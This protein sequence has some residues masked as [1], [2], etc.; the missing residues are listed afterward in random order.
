MFTV[1]YG[2]VYYH[3]WHY[4]SDSFT[5]R[6]NSIPLQYVY[7]DSVFPAFHQQNIYCF[8]SQQI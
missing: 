2:T 8:K 6:F 3:I 4:S 1:I 7:Y 5:D